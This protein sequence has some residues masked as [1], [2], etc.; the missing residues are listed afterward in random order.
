MVLK[1]S[2]GSY[3]EMF[4]L[5]KLV[6]QMRMSVSIRIWT[7]DKNLLLY[8]KNGMLTNAEAEGDD[9]LLLNFNY[10]NGKVQIEDFL[11]TAFL[12]FLLDFTNVSFESISKKVSGILNIPN[13]ESIFLDAV[14]E[15]DEM[16]DF[17]RIKISKILPEK[18]S[19]PQSW[20]L[21]FLGYIM[22]GYGFVQSILAVGKPKETY[23]AYK[24]LK[25][26]GVVLTSE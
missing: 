23:N 5:I 8:F 20:A 3:N 22:S 26:K 9:F 10:N 11:R 17:R 19:N 6:S 21:I 25:S 15:L 13:I 18:I 1:G 14:R 7:S 12:G 2:F 24:D 16:S 4:D